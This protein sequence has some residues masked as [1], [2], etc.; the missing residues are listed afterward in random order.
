MDKYF[1]KRC[2]NVSFIDSNYIGEG[3]ISNNL[4][5]NKNDTSLVNVIINVE[6]SKINTG[7]DLNDSINLNI[8]GEAT[9][10]SNIKK[11]YFSYNQKIKITEYIKPITE[12][13]IDQTSIKIEKVNMKKIGLLK[14]ELDVILQ[15]DNATNFECEV[16][17]FNVDI[18]SN[19]NKDKIVAKSVANGNFLLLSDTITSIKTNIDINNLEIGKSILSNSVN[20]KNQFFILAVGEIHYFGFKIPLKIERILFY[21]PV[22]LE[23]ELDE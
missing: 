18:Y 1:I 14:S 7:L 20:G 19:S 10:N 4:N 13:F 9:I 8:R 2:E 15:I 23:F 11:Y 17:N 16:S 21:N 3:K 12:K 6:K 5:I 22:T